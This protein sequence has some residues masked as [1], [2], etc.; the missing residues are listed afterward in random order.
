MS[1][2]ARELEE[3]LQSLDPERAKY[4]EALIRE[5]FEKVESEETPPK[6]GWPVHYFEETAGALAGEEFERP[7]Q[8]ELPRRQRT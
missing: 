1:P 7:P 4:L 6:Q 2:L 5:A 8:G 3:K